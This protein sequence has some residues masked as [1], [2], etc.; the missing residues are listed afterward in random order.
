MK[1]TLEALLNQH[2]KIDRFKLLSSKDILAK[3]ELATIRARS[4]SN[5]DRWNSN[6]VWCSA[7]DEWRTLMQSGSDEEIILAM[8]DPGENANRLRQS[9][10]Y[11]GL[12]SQERRNELII[13]AGLSPPSAESMEKASA[14]LAAGF[15]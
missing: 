14:L 1:N 5:L 6:G 4:L 8:T 10:P 9:P 15:I 12:L 13:E 7:H 3:F 11:V 2:D